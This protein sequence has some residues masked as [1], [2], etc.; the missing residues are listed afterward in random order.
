MLSK[1]IGTVALT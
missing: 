1:Q